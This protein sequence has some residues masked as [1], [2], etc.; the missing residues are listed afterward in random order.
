MVSTRKSDNY[1]KKYLTDKIAQNGVTQSQ[2][3]IVVTQTLLLDDTE[4]KCNDFRK[5]K[6]Y[7][8]DIENCIQKSDYHIYLPD[9]TEGSEMQDYL[10][11]NN[12]L[13]KLVALISQP[14]IVTPTAIERTMQIAYNAKYNSG[15]ISRQVGAAITDEFYSV[16]S[17]GWNE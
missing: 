10:D 1:R 13:V 14:G 17:V 11:I 12:Q 8:P 5:G 16:K 2:T 9:S 4:Y 6:F 15:C 7:S 3:S